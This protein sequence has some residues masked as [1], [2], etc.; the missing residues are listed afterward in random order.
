MKAVKQRKLSF[1]LR[2]DGWFSVFGLFLG[3]RR[4]E[5]IR[6]VQGRAVSV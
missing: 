1:L 2:A 6:K 3:D 5:R 4:A